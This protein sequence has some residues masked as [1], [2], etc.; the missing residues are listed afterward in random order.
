MSLHFDG[1]RI[2]RARA[3]AGDDHA[4][5]RRT[6]DAFCVDIARRIADQTGYVVQTREKVRLYMVEMLDRIGP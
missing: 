5:E 1:L 3:E 2:D 4:D 6:V